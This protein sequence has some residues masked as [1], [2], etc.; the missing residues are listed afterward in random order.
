VSVTPEPDPRNTGRPS[1]PARRLTRVQQLT[2]NVWRH[3]SAAV[4][5][6]V[7][8]GDILDQVAIQAVVAA[9]HDTTDPLDLFVRHQH[10]EE[11]YA[12]VRSLVAP[13]RTTDDMLNLLDSGFLLRW[14]ELTGHGRGPE[15][16]P[17][18]TR[19]SG[20]QRLLP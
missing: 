14:Q 17:P 9:L 11:E 5:R 7:M 15:E 18:L 2:L 4:S 6:R 19:R 20:P 12:L 10:G 8:P 13:D 1:Q 16:L 3:A